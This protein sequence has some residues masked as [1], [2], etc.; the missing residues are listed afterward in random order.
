MCWTHI[1]TLVPQCDLKR[2]NVTVTFFTHLIVWEVTGG[3]ETFLCTLRGDLMFPQDICVSICFLGIFVSISFPS[4]RF[5]AWQAPMVVL[6]SQSMMERPNSASTW[7][8]FTTL[9]VLYCFPLPYFSL[10]TTFSCFPPISLSFCSLPLFITFITSI[11][12][13]WMFSSWF[14]QPLVCDFKGC[15]WGQGCSWRRFIAAPWYLLDTSQ[16]ASEP[17]PSLFCL[18]S[19]VPN[20]NL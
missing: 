1:C 17:L 20:F 8:I 4:Q 15:V 19:S 2:P 6:M 3:P 13:T 14:H 5:C 10:S 12:L 16:D 7:Y 18:F 11:L 9:A